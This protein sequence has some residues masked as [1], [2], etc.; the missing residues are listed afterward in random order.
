MNALGEK[1]CSLMRWQCAYIKKHEIVLMR[2]PARC[3]R[4][5]ILISGDSSKSSKAKEWTVC[6]NL[7]ER[8]FCFVDNYLWRQKLTQQTSFWSQGRHTHV[9]LRSCPMGGV[10]S[11]CRRFG[12]PNKIQYDFYDGNTGAW[13]H[14]PSQKRRLIYLMHRDPS[15]GKCNRWSIRKRSE[16]IKTPVFYLF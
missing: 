2:L 13:S 11:H 12:V 15:F 16:K 10:H 9:L 7:S 14:A 4:L 1:S 6:R 8:P 3:A 5:N